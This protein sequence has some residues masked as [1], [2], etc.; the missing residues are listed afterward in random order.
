[1]FESIPFI[2]SAE[3]LIDRAFR[4]S[5]KKFIADK[6]SLYQQ[7]KTIIAQTESFGTFLVN[8]LH[9]YVHGFPSIEQLPGFYQEILRIKIDI[10]VLKKSLG[11]I[12]WAETTCQKI[13][14]SQMKNLKKAKNINFLK[15]K[16]KEIFGRLSSVVLQISKNLDILVSTQYM[17]KKL[18]HLQDIPT[19]V[20]CGYP[21]VG[22]S[23]LLRCLSR[24][25]PEIAQYPF[26]TKEIHVGHMQ[27]KE[28][29]C[30]KIFQIIDTPGLLDKP[31]EKRN[32]IEQLAIAALTNLAD[33]V[34]F[35]LDPSEIC[36]YSI[37]DQRKL[38]LYLR[39]KLDDVK[40]IV[41][42]C[43]SDIYQ[44]ED[45]DLSISCITGEGINELRTL[46]FS[47][48]YPK[49]LLLD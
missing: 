14:I 4:K 3:N 9:E 10:N 41:V 47:K 23:S 12:K 33:V 37:E 8:S 30:L 27:K 25:T 40:M 28:K 39:K 18:P 7:K 13:L 34:I 43:K 2:L 49:E 5:K 45:D 48:Y 42:K 15:E 6:N 19:I 38:Y 20:L 32:K 11:A 22:K 21:N 31:I 26:T 36:G 46:L 17:I 35:I 29:F 16:Q 1:M 44:I 24:A